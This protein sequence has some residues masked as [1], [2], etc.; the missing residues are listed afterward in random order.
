MFNSIKEFF[1]GKPK[2]EEPPVPNTVEPPTVVVTEPAVSEPVAVAAAAQPV[3]EVI[4]PDTV[5]ISLADNMSVSIGQPDTI[6]LTQPQ[7]NPGVWPFPNSAPLESEV[8]KKRTSVKQE[9]VTDKKP[10]PAIKVNKNKP[11]KKK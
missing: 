10:T 11:R 7:I 1:V 8:K 9:S 4:N 5:T 3:T 6:I 2:V